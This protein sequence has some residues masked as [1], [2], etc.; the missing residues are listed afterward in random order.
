MSTIENAEVIR[1]EHLNHEASIKSIGSLYYLAAILLPL[2]ALGFALDPKAESL[3]R[4]L[5]PVLLILLS[6]AYFQ[7][8]R[9]FRALN[10]KAKMPA[11]ILAVIGLLGIPL[12]TLINGYILYLIHSQKGKM[13]FSDEYKTIIAETPDIKYKTSLLVWIF[14]GLLVL[15]ILIGIL[16]AVFVK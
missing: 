4:W 11:T 16:A 5:V 8:G 3:G 2:G 15:L 9:W 7:M 14:I 6:A 12:G 1:K 10:P 13:V